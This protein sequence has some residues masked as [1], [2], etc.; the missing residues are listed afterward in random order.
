MNVWWIENLTIWCCEQWF[1]FFFSPSF[2]LSHPFF[3]SGHLPCLF[4]SCHYLWLSFFARYSYRKV[5]IHLPVIFTCGSTYAGAH[6][7]IVQNRWADTCD[8]AHTCMNAHT[9]IWTN[10]HVPLHMFTC[11]LTYTCIYAWCGSG[12]PVGWGFHCIPEWSQSLP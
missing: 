2:S 9:Y 3:V 5:C 11:G 1:L 4:F 10:T 7:Y 12:T 6:T 8:R